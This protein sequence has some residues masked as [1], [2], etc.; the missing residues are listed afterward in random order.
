M[1]VKKMFSKIIV[2]GIFILSSMFIASNVN[3]ATQTSIVLG[4]E[5]YRTSGLA[6]M[7]EERIAWKIS[8]YDS[9]T[10]TTA[11]QSRTIYCIK[12][13]PG[14]GSSQ[15]GNGTVM[16]RTYI[17]VGNLK[18]YSEIESPYKEVLPTGENYNSLVWVLDHSYV[19]AKN[20]SEQ[21]AAQ[22]FRSKLL[23]AAG[24]SAGTTISDDEID[25]AQQLAVWYFTN[26]D[27]Y[28]ITNETFSLW[29]K[30]IEDTDYMALGDKFVD[31]DYRND[32]A[33]DL[34]IYLVNGGLANKDVAPTVNGQNTITIV[35]TAAAA[36]K[37]AVDKYIVGPYKLETDATEYTLNGILKN[38]EETELSYTI[39]DSNK[40]ETTKTLE[41]LELA[42]EEFYL[43]VT[44]TGSM[45][46]ATFK[47]T[48][49]EYN[50]ELTYWSVA[51]ANPVDQPVVEVERTKKE[52]A[53]KRIF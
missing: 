36:E 38:S 37:V 30:S 8:S 15:M 28:K 35:D 22:E 45:K 12:G 18:N 2:T 41:E 53:P 6:Y 47:V 34:F 4:L 51:G 17:N 14:F 40:Q 7:T 48:M 33:I 31:G 5:E 52:A 20:T 46:D 13:G 9:L 27:N 16:K 49:V 11:D 10:S 21:V 1:K 32:D 25:I 44:T 43:S 26:N 3:A 24:I 39:L 42:G 19:P 23:Q 50:T 29:V